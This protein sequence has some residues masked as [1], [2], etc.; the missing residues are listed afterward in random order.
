MNETLHT[1]MTVC[2]ED[3]EVGDRFYYENTQVAVQTITLVDDH[4]VVLRMEAFVLG[5]CVPRLGSLA[6]GELIDIIR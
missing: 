4:K 3:L 1:P 6:K 2:A 5:R